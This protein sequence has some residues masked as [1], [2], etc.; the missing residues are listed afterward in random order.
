MRNDHLCA[1]RGSFYGPFELTV[2]LISL[3]LFDPFAIHLRFRPLPLAQV[4]QHWRRQ[5]PT[6]VVI[7]LVLLVGVTSAPLG[8][9]DRVTVP[10]QQIEPL[11]HQSAI[12]QLG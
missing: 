3:S 7:V 5:Q 6:P 10:Q 9:L 2:C 8:S 11:E 4:S 1:F 12:E